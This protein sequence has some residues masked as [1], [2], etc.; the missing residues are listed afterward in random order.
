MRTLLALLLLSPAALAQDSVG[1]AGGFPGAALDPGSTTGTS[2]NER[3][4]TR[5][6]D[7]T[8]VGRL[9][10]WP[11]CTADPQAAGRGDGAAT[12]AAGP[13]RDLSTWWSATSRTNSNWPTVATTRAGS[14]APWFASHRSGAVSSQHAAE[15]DSSATHTTDA[16]ARVAQRVA[17]LG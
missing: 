4:S 9:V 13:G 2:T 15:R 17:Q 8:G 11:T 16:F 5:A 12:H 6:P 7:N 3:V 14:T 1:K 10:L